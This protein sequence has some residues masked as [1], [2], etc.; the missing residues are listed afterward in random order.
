MLGF[1]YSESRSVVWC[2]IILISWLKIQKPDGVMR[3]RHM[4]GDFHKDIDKLVNIE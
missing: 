4:S 2:T 1:N 3:M